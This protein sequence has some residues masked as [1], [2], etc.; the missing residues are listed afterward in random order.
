MAQII[1]LP[2]L[3][4]LAPRFGIP[5]PEYLT[6]DASG[7]KIRDALKR[8]SGK[9]IVK[10]DVMTGKRGKAG[11]VKVVRDYLDAEKA[12]KQIQG[13]EVRGFIPRTAYMVQ[14]IPSDIGN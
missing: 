13:M 3:E 7:A 12:L 14:Y 11:A 6:A 9:A 2:F 10:A 5:V 1:E 4:H 8:W